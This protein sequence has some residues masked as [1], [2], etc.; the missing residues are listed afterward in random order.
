MENDNAVGHEAQELAK[1]MQAV[2]YCTAALSC[3]LPANVCPVTVCP[4]TICP[5]T[6]CP[7]T[8]CPVMLVRT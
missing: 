3:W 6:V 8:V 4:V 2:R 1:L 5:V 7:V